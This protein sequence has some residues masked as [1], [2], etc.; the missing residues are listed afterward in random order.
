MR[1][2][3]RGTIAAKTDALA[4]FQGERQ[5]ETALGPGLS[6]RI[7]AVKIRLADL[8]PA[9]MIALGLA[10]TLAW[11]GLLTG[12]LVWGLVRAI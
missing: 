5:A 2:R 3:G 4:A 1:I 6:A 7:M 9:T 11:T 10:L 8:W 12:L